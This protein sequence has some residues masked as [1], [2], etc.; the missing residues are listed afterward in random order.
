[1]TTSISLPRDDR[2][3]RRHG[4]AQPPFAA[5]VAEKTPAQ[6]EKPRR[7]RRERAARATTR[8]KACG[9]DDAKLSVD[10]VE[11]QLMSCASSSMCRQHHLGVGLLEQV[12]PP[13]RRDREMQQI[14]RLV[15][16]DVRGDPVS[17]DLE[18]QRVIRTVLSG[19]D[20]GKQHLSPHRSERL[21]QSGARSGPAAPH[22]VRCGPRPSAARAAHHMASDEET[23]PAPVTG[24]VPHRCEWW[25]ASP[26]VTP[27]PR[28]VTWLHTHPPVRPAQAR[29]S[30]RRCR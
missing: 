6:A 1:M 27:V 22:A 11:E 2:A 30:G 25:E 8:V 7:H 13:Q 4:L 5:P 21:H 16:Y 29:A 18:Q 26:A 23:G 17:R 9:A 24:D 20:P 14:S 3:G 12:Q 10:A 15:S 19:R 28:A